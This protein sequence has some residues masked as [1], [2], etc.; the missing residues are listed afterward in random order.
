MQNK[1]IDLEVANQTPSPTVDPSVHVILC[2]HSMGGIV[3]AETLLS[4]ARD[5]PVPSSYANDTTN[6][7]TTRPTSSHKQPTHLDPPDPD[8]R[9][10]SAPPQ[11]PSRLFFPHV[12]AV[13]AFDTPFLGISP[14]VLAHGAEEQLNNAS[15]AYK[16]FENASNCCHRICLAVWLCPWSR[17]P[18]TAS[19]W[20]FL[21]HRQLGDSG[22]LRL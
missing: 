8:D 13:L 7:T 20:L 11:E 16:A 15:S 6:N 22:S 17:T 21:L 12:Q 4:I 3:A 2:G 18:S 1:V 19:A 10:S 14:G 9:P 5:E